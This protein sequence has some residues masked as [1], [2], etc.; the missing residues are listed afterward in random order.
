MHVAELG[1][2]HDVPAGGRGRGLA[3]VA[4]RGQQ[5]MQPHVG[6]GAGVEQVVVGVDGAGEHLDQG[7]LAHVAV[8]DGLEHKAQR[9]TFLLGDGV[10]LLAPGQDLEPRSIQRRGPLLHDQVQQ[11]I[12]ADP[13]GGA[14]AHHREHAGLRHPAGQGVGQ[15]AEG[16]QVTVEVALQK[17]VVGHHDAFDEGVVDLVFPI[18]QLVGD[19]TLGGGAVAV[20]VRGVRQQVRDAVEGGLRP[21]RQ[22]QRG[23]A[24]SQ[25]GLQLAD[26]VVEVSP[27]PVDLGHEHRPGDAEVSGGAPDQLGLHLD[28]VDR[29]D[30]EHGEVS[31]AERGHHLADVIREAGGVDQVD[32]VVP[33]L[34]LRQ[35]QGHAHALV[36]LL[37]IVVH[38]PADPADG[39]RTQQHGLGQRGLPRAAMTDQSHIADLR[40]RV[41]LH[42]TH[43]RG[44]S[45]SSDPTVSIRRA[46][47]EVNQLCPGRG[48]CPP[49]R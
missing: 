9:V 17:G 35:R 26:D 41:A 4:D 27:L 48:S 19:R 5:R 16:G 2:R 29:A 18:G 24:C 33:P 38:D 44:F 39:P 15:F 43:P 47:D 46:L 3:V 21:D 6:P 10:D 1:H 49:D 28:A 7:Q 22:L 36:L 42:E 40:G 32:L 12:N 8:S 11:P 37:G 25:T 23:D 31:D 13:A 14:A 34:E 45:F 30:H 20:G